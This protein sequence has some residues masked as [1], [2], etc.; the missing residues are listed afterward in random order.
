MTAT[1]ICPYPIFS[2]LANLDTLL[3]V[4]SLDPLQH[5]L[6]T[7]VPPPAR[8]V[9]PAVLTGRSGVVVGLESGPDPTTNVA[10]TAMVS[11]FNPR[12][13][14]PLLDRRH[15]LTSKT[16]PANPGLPSQLN[17]DFGFTKS[18]TIPRPTEPQFNPALSPSG[19]PRQQDYHRLLRVPLHTD[20][21]CVSMSDL[22]HTQ[23]GFSNPLA[24][25]GPLR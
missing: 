12:A 22:L 11:L 23:P 5:Q 3:P 21:I 17:I 20:V 6:G 8:T 18:L 2:F 9:F 24:T 15:A 16:P 14:P 19:P 1:I 25:A 7:G 13:R 4:D 10:T